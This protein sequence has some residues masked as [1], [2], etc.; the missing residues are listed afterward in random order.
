MAE[1]LTPIQLWT[2]GSG[3]SSGPIGWAWVLVHEPTGT[4]RE[5]HGGGLEGTNNR[6]ELYAVIKGFEALK[7]PCAVTVHTDSEYVGKAFPQGWIA[8]WKRKQWRGVKNPDLWQM[9][10]KLVQVHDVR[11]RWVPGHSGVAL[12]ESCDKRAG[13]CRRAI[14]AALAED[15][16]ISGLSFEIVDLPLGRQLALGA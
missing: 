3:T 12:N 2:D 14:K 4:M 15:S 9:L 5:G 8:R 1:G 7:R 11:W 10:D 6:A 16:P 13:E